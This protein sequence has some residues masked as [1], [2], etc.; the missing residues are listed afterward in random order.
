MQPASTVMVAEATSISSIR[1]I[2]SSESAMAPSALAPPA[3]PVLP[4]QGVTFAPAAWAIRSTVA[5][6]SVLEGQTT[7]R[8]FPS[9]AQIPTAR[10]SASAPVN[11]APGASAA[12]RLSATRSR[13]AMVSDIGR[14]YARLRPPPIAPEGSPR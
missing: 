1:R 9:R 3:R 13:A 5:T 11:T 2:R 14:A 12:A 4:P 6:S 8:G 7:A 10:S